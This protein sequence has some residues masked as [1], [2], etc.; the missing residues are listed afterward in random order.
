MV[1]SGMSLGT[2]PSG[3]RHFRQ[4]LSGRGAT[5][6]QPGNCWSCSV[7]FNSNFAPPESIQDGHD[8]WVPATIRAVAHFQGIM[9]TELYL[10]AVRRERSNSAT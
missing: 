2:A 3:A 7:P 4:V 10:V 9:Y 6:S 5:A 1:C 8:L